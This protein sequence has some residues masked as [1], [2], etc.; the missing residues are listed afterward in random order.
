MHSKPVYLNLFTF[1]FPVTAITSILH[2]IS[3]VL[4]FFFI[5]F[6]LSQLDTLLHYHKAF[7]QMRDVFLNRPEK[8]IVLLV[9]LCFFAFH[10]F[11]GLRHLIM[12]VGYAED[13][14]AATIS[15]YFVYILTIF[16]MIMMGYAIW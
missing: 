10:F 1:K 2:R 9:G 12:D 5:P 14:R 13:Q 4:L 15:S 11:A 3:G 8:K 7:A 16:A 6:F